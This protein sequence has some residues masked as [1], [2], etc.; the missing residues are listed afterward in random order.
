[1]GRSAVGIAQWLVYTRFHCPTYKRGLTFNHSQGQAINEEDDV[2]N[3][4]LV[5]ARH[6]KLVS[7][8]VFVAFRVIKV[9]HLYCLTTAAFT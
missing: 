6:F 9:N 4:V 7:T 1:M 2:W 5:Y 3:D 8:Q